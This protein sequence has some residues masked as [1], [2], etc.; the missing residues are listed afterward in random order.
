V[1]L[2]LGAGDG[3]V[4]QEQSLAARAN[5]ASIAA[6]DLNGDGKCDLVLSDY[7][8]HNVTLMFGNG[9]GT[10]QTQRIPMPLSSSRNPI[11]LTDLNHD[12]LID[13]TFPTGSAQDTPAAALMSEL[14]AVGTRR[15]PGVAPAD[16]MRTVLRRR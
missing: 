2:L 6:A 10:F 13:I 4:Q 16:S 15:T 8:S 14:L 7:Q 9:D 5:P 1:N 12:G 3:T 11:E